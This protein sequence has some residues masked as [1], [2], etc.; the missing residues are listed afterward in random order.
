M[1]ALILKKSAHIFILSLFIVATSTVLLRATV[2][3]PGGGGGTTTPIWLD[4]WSFGD[5]NTWE[6]DRGHV[7]ISFTNLSSSL[8]G[9]WTALVLD[10]TNA[11]WL[12]YEVVEADGTTHLKVERGSVMFWFAPSWSGTNAGGNGPGQWGRLIEVGAYTTNASY[13]WWSLYTDPAGANLYFAAQTNGSEALYLS[14]PIVWTT[15]RWHLIALTYSATNSVLYLDG[16][17]ATNGL[18]VTIWPGAD[19][20]SNGFFIGSDSTGGAQARGMYDDLSTYDVPL[21]ESAIASAFVIDS[22]YYYMNPANFANILGSAGSQPTFGPLFNA[23]T[24]WG[25]LSSAVTNSIG[26]I[27]SSS[28][29][30][31]NVS[32]AGAANGKMNSTFTIAGGT[33]GTRYDVFASSILF[34]ASSTNAWAWMGQGYHCTTYTLTNLPHTST[35]VLLGTPRDGDFDGLTDAFEQLVSKTD[36]NN[37][38]TDGDGML[39]G[40]EIMWGL[41]PKDLNESDQT[42]K[43][44][45]YVYDGTGW[46]TNLH[47]IRSEVF[48]LDA[49]GNVQVSQ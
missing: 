31:T 19:V 13:G 49:E 10:H 17:F 20:L 16:V 6:C 26:C 29:W 44:I 14:M 21:A 8:L 48:G 23:I 25:Y 5:T 40:W 18:G 37:S 42:G 30:L 15:N 34:P 39:D 36:S 4:Y 24:G 12:Q 46:L 27:E 47:G 11:A 2:P 38:D 9:N 7:P 28:I 33:N 1:K 45:N 41:N 43:R 35:Y 32:A 3:D 22:F